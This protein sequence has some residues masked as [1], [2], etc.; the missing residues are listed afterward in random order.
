MV[1]ENAAEL[2]APGE[3]SPPSGNKR[4]VAKNASIYLASQLVTWLVTFVSIA[5]IPRLLGAATLGKL[6]FV[7]NL[8]GTA[9]VFFQ[10]GIDSYL[11][12]E[13]GRDERQTE[14]LMRATFGLRLV[15]SL[16]TAA[17]IWAV[18]FFSKHDPIYWRIFLFGLPGIP[19]TYFYAA[20]RA[21]FTGSERA[22]QVMLLDIMTAALPLF[23]L[24]F[25][26]AGAVLRDV[27]LLSA[28]SVIAGLITVG[29]TLLLLRKSIRVRPT[30]DFLLWGRLLRGGLPFVVNGFILTLYAFI[31]IAELRYYAGDAAVGVLSQAQKLFG[32]FLFVPTALGAALLPSLSRMAQAGQ[33]EFKKMQTQVLSL[34]ILLGLPMTVGVMLLARPL[35]LLLY[36]AHEG[37]EFQSMPLTLQV[38]A[39]IIIPMYVVSTMYQFLVAQNRNGLWSGFL[40]ASVGLCAASG[41]FLIPYFRDH[42]QAGAIGA[43]AAILVAETASMLF[44]F[45]LLKTNPFDRETLSRVFRAWLAASAMAVVIFFILHLFY[46][47][48]GNLQEAPLTLLLELFLCAA[49]GAGTFAVWGWILRVLSPEEQEKVTRLVRRKLVRK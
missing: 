45:L 28:S 26:R 48:P 24:P 16:P 15:V 11:I 22:K 17:I 41:M 46:L 1:I 18:L 33:E 29:A 31:T 20:T 30:V 23:C 40:V 38:Y 21:V 6:A 27:T 36:R 49:L 4:R 13:I 47:L 19:L 7:G 37:S 32:T 9:M 35:S 2:S 14:S 34:L 42:Y 39:L 3:N 44:A 43:V 12:K 5:I 8:Y 10:F 25:L